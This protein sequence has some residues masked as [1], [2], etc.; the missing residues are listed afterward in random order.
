MQWGL[1]KGILK[2]IWAGGAGDEG[3]LT[4]DQFVPGLYLMD[5][6]KRVIGNEASHIKHCTGGPYSLGHLTTDNMCDT[7]SYSANSPG[8]TCHVRE[9][10]ALCCMQ[11]CG[12]KPTRRGKENAESKGTQ[13]CLANTHAPSPESTLTTRCWPLLSNRSSPAVHFAVPC[14]AG[15]DLPHAGH[16]FS[17]LPT[18]AVQILSWPWAAVPCSAEQ[19][20]S[21]MCFCLAPVILPLM[22]SCV[23]LYAG[24]V[25]LETPCPGGG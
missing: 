22:Q 18:K 16:A 13:A 11:T 10:P 6:A 4:A 25:S 9:L 20:F 23:H 19:G 17:C 5:N 1:P 12:L 24:N 15:A 7:C 21:H 2:D 8:L 14:P 3:R